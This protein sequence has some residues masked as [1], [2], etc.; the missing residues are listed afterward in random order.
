[1]KLQCSSRSEEHRDDPEGVGAGPHGNEM[2]LQRISRQ[3][4]VR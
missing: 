2:R 1:M 4:R 3:S